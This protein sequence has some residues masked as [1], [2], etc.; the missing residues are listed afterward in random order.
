MVNLIKFIS[1]E[2]VIYN[3]K[4]KLEILESVQLILNQMISII[5]FWS[6]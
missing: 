4:N 3:Q 2:S 6:L 5:I 1:D